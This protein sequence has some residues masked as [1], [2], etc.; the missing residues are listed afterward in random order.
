MK[1]VTLDFETYYDN[2]YSLRK[3]ATEDYVIDPRFE[4]ILVSVRAEGEGTKWFS[5]TKKQT[6]EW[7]AQFELGKQAVIAHNMR[8]DGLILE[9]HFATRPAMYMDT[10]LMANAV[11]KPHTGRVSLAK[12]LEYLHLGAKGDEVHNMLGRH[13]QSLTRDELLKYARYCCND[14]DTTYTLFRHLVEDFPRD[15][16]KIIDLSTRM[17]LEPRLELDGAL[18]AEH[19]Q[20]VKA[21]KEAALAAVLSQVSKDD[22]MSNKKFSDILERLGYTVPMKRSP[23]T[24][25]MTPALA[26]NDAEFKDFAEEHEDDPVIGPMLQARLSTKSTL[27]ETRSARLLGMAT[28]QLPLRV[29]L[30]YYAAHTGRYGGSESINLQNL[31]QPHKSKIRFALR[32]PKGS[33]VLGADLSQIEARCSAVVA[34]QR[35]LV[36][37]FRAGRDVYAEF[38]T[39]LYGRPIT[40]ADKRERF[41]SKTAVLGLQYG[42]GAKKFIVTAR[43][44]EVKVDISEA[45]K[46]VDTYRTTYSRVPSFWYELERALNQMC[47]GAKG[48]IGDLIHYSRFRVETPAGMPLEYA[49]LEPDPDNGGFAYTYGSAVRRMW[50]GKLFENLIQKMARDIVMANMLRIRSEL[51]L[52]PVLQ[53][54]DELDYVVPEREAETTAAAIHKIMTAPPSW[55]PG[56]PVDV[57]IHWGATFGDVK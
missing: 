35:N 17:Y 34:G 57:E 8:F 25:K 54:H 21:K 24:G 44:G 1:L 33:V 2:E 36:E 20:A 7:L 48:H 42:M 19:L 39:A 50:G 46:I 52:S 30:V 15:E 29:P 27:E 47:N 5:G 11:I 32:A 40:R 18:L 6:A 14:V 22:L 10:M 56:L 16:L 3:M 23:T 37:A 4:V 28:R 12:C 43:T 26:K 53:V 41:L 51:G 13:R 31:P 45:Q 38:G 55:M 49:S 9:H